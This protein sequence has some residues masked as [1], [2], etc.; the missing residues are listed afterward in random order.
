MAGRSAD[1]DAEYWLR[2]SKEY[3]D[4]LRV[5]NEEDATALKTIF[6][7]VFGLQARLKSE[8][9]ASL[10]A[11]F[12]NGE[13]HTRV[14]DSLRTALESARKIVAGEEGGP[15]A[16]RHDLAHLGDVLRK[17][18]DWFKTLETGGASSPSAIE[19]ELVDI[20][21]SIDRIVQEARASSVTRVSADKKILT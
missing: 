15:D 9:L 7:A 20:T 16:A 10:A 8:S 17:T 3:S 11:G 1:P 4:L 18:L 5:L 13:L 19:A 2:V 14:K 21:Q 6:L 12:E